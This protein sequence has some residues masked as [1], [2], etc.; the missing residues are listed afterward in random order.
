MLASGKPL[1]IS[2]LQEAIMSR[3]HAGMEANLGEYAYPYE[4][5]RPELASLYPLVEECY[6]VSS[7]SW[8]PSVQSCLNLSN[9]SSNAIQSVDRGTSCCLSVDVVSPDLRG[10]G[11]KKDC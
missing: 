10:M 3:L 1:R 5:H 6:A 4:H 8:P 7:P 2:Y 9:G 11:F